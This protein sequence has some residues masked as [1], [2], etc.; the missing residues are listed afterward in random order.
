[1]S[2]YKDMTLEEYKEHFDQILSGAVNDPVYDDPEYVNYVK[3]NRSRT[4]RWEKQA[5]ISDDMTQLLKNIDQPLQWEVITEPWCGDSSQI[6]PFLEK[7]VALNDNFKLNIQLRDSD[8]EIESYL[9]NG[10]K[11]V[12]KIVVRNAV[13]DDLFSW[14]PRPKGAQELVIRQK[15]M[16]LST[17]DKYMNLLKWYTD[18][19]GAEIQDEL[20]AHFKSSVK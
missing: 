15:E 19:K 9:T 14:G 20:V 4:K 16:D 3:L 12:P 7:M 13:G 8:S 18:D 10:T 1:M 6:V 11:S 17:I 2:K 5:E